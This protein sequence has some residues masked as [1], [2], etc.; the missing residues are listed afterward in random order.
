RFPHHGHGAGDGALREVARGGSHVLPQVI[1]PEEAARLV[2]AFGGGGGV[3]ESPAR[4]EPRGL[5]GHA[6]VDEPFGFEVD[7][8]PDLV[9]E[10][11]VRASPAPSYVDIRP[12]AYALFVVGRSSG[13]VA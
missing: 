13:V 12:E 4:G 6:F 1:Q 3:A 7:V 5:R 10:V 8:R 11:V 9:G 2:E